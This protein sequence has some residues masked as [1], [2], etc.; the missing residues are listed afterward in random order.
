MT[1]FS[2][3]HN[4]MAKRSHY[5]I[6][7]F[8]TSEFLTMDTTHIHSIVLH[9]PPFLPSPLAYH[10]DMYY[11]GLCTQGLSARGYGWD[12][13][14]RA[15]EGHGNTLEDYHQRRLRTIMA[16]KV[17][18]SMASVLQVVD[19]CWESLPVQARFGLQ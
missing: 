6:M 5:C 1:M 14:Y 2:F 16:S 17:L 15:E 12:P 19:S 13:S 11:Q 8:L 10:P 18:P 9:F 7:I 3:S 4:H